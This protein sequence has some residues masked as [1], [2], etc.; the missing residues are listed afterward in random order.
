M[1]ITRKLATLVAALATVAAVS[2]QAEAALLTINDGVDVWTLDVTTGCT[3]CTVTLSADFNAGSARIGTFLDSVQWDLTNPNVN[4]TNVTSPTFLTSTTA[5]MAANWA[6]LE[7]NLNANNCTGGNENAV[8]GFYSTN[9]VGP[10]T[11]TTNYQW[12]FSAQFASTLASVTAGNIRAAFN[13]ADGSNAGIFSPGG[14]TFVT[15][16]ATPTSTTTPTTGNVP[17][18]ASLSLF[19]AALVAAAYRLRR[20][21]NA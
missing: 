19:G 16:T 5:G 14:G 15:T 3:T 9:G 2:T 10:I 6:F 1:S 17:E 20:R 7:A 8:C 21:R 18:P 13:N 12:V 11:A 4:P